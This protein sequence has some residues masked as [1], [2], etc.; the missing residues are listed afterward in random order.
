MK[1]KDGWERGEESRDLTASSKALPG[2]AANLWEFP[3]VIRQA[4]REQVLKP[5]RGKSEQRSRN[6]ARSAPATE[7]PAAGCCRDRA[8]GE[9]CGVGSPGEHGYGVPY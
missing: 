3:L 8:L 5:R 6:P 7:L 1:E 9:C 4:K 2:S